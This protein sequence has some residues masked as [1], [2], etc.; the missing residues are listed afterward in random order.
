MAS[1][2][3]RLARVTYEAAGEGWQVVSGFESSGKIVYHKAIAGVN[4]R[5]DAV[6]GHVQL[7]YPEPY[8]G[9]YDP[10]VKPIADSLDFAPC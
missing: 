2:R 3:H 4:C 5:G 6:L 8:R 10:L 9:L 7:R 1:V